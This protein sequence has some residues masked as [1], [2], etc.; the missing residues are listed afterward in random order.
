MVIDTDPFPTVTVSLVDAH[1]PRDKVKGKAKFVP[2][3]FVPKQ[4]SWPRLKI[5]L[6]SNKPPKGFSGPSI[7]ELVS[8]SSAKKLDVPMVLCSW[9]KSDVVLTGSKEKPLWAKIPLQAP[10]T[11][12]ISQ[13]EFH[14]K[15]SAN[16]LYGLPK[17]CQEALDLSLTCL[18]AKQIIQKTTDPRMKA[19]LQH[20]YQVNNICK[21]DTSPENPKD[22]NHDLM[23]KLKVAIAELFPHSSSINLHY[24]KPLYVTAYIE[25][26]PISK[27]SSIMEQW[28]TSCP[29]LS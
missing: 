27:I 9:C 23:D 11:A 20:T 7:V 13:K 14:K 18:N 3:Q 17:A 4:N 21:Q 2:M 28:S 8:Y 22:E 29:F 10:T 16:N 12:A 6:F 24:L 1:L 15:H 26:Y 5:D 19:R 25:G